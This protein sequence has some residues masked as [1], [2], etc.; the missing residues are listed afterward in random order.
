MSNLGRGG[1][2]TLVEVLIALAISALV[3]VIAY[4]SF[5]TVLS[6]VEASQAS[7]DRVYEV[8]RA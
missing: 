5:T 7:A 2:F 3:S 1:G 8:N 6:G 4:S